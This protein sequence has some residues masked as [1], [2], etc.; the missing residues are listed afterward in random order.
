M[1]LGSFSTF[2]LVLLMNVLLSVPYT[3]PVC[4]SYNGLPLL[5]G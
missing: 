4:G 2:S 1:A 5:P 3:S